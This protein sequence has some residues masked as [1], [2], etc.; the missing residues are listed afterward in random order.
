MKLLFIL[1]FTFGLTNVLDRYDT[2]K[3]HQIYI[4]D[5]NDEVILDFEDLIKLINEPKI[6][7][8]DYSLDI[9]QLK[10]DIIDVK[11]SI[12]ELKSLYDLNY[13]KTESLDLDFIGI[14]RTLKSKMLVMESRISLIENDIDSLKNNKYNLLTNSDFIDRISFDLIENSQSLDSQ[15]VKIDEVYSGKIDTEINLDLD[16]INQITNS[17]LQSQSSN[18]FNSNSFDIAPIS[19]PSQG[20]EDFLIYPQIAIDSEVEGVV[21]LEYYIKND[22]KVDSE[23]IKILDGIPMLNKSAIDAVSKSIWTPAY[24][25]DSPVGVYVTTPVVFQ[26]R[27]NSLEP[28][29]KPKER[30]FLRKGFFNNKAND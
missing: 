5:E 22:G 23:S 14:E 28:V 15:N 12:E 27:D 20:I 24:K 21:Y 2:L 8:I 13:D 19:L 9:A 11:R 25:N 16:T 26:L 4:L 30:K 3:A 17:E 29:L 7:F 6:E 18:I 1:L 10:K